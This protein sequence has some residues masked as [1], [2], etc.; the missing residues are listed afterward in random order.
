MTT[1]GSCIGL[2]YLA[3][4]VC[5]VSFRL[6]REPTVLGLD[7]SR[8]IKPRLEGLSDL[9]PGQNV[10]A[11]VSKI[12]RLLTSDVSGMVQKVVHVQILTETRNELSFHSVTARG[13]SSQCKG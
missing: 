4:L 12:P 10:T 6:R 3:F 13:K 7:I 1:G 11:M 2:N 5:I 8:T 9:L